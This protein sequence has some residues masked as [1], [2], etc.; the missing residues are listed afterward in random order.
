MPKTK[1]RFKNKTLKNRAKANK[2][3][4]LW[5]WSKDAWHAYK[6]KKKHGII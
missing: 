4:W 2:P 3:V 5:K 1:F 6:E